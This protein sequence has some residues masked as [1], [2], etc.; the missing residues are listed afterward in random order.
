MIQN[1]M[2]DQR[3]EYAL[4]LMQFS[5]DCATDAILGV[6]ADARFI[7]VNAAACRMLGYTP[8]ELLTMTVHDVD[9]NLSSEGWTQYW[10]ALKQR[11]SLLL[12]TQY[13]LKNGCIFPV[14]VT[15]NYVECDGIEYSCSFIRDIAE[16]KLAEFALRE[17]EDRFRCLIEGAADAFFLHDLEGRI[18]DVNQQA[19]H[20]LGYS[21]AELIGLSIQDIEQE[22]FSDAAWQNLL[23][24]QPITVSSVHQRKDG[25]TFPVETRLSAI[26]LAGARLILA[27]TRDVSERARLEAERERAREQLRRY[28]FYDTLTGLPNRTLLLEHL[29]QL[30]QANNGNQFALLCF[31]LDRFETVKYSFGHSVGERLLLAAIERLKDSLPA[32]AFMAR[33]E[34]GEFVILVEQISSQTEAIHLAEQLQKKLTT[35]FHLNSHEVFTTISIGIV[36]SSAPYHQAMDFLRAADIAMHRAKTTGATQYVV[37]DAEM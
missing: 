29:E 22:H 31:N 3:G 34:S 12:E 1:T 32:S 36:L 9:L 28:A 5:M 14:E 24:G 15:A 26:D 17:S 20:S 8:E 18:I 33:I 27:L 11:R 10:E 16:R 13:Q 4:K 35:P 37:F 19:C 21:H 2:P 7:Y 6:R 25:L 23:P 30:L